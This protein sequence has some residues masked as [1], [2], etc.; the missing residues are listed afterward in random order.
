[1]SI[2]AHASRIERSDLAVGRAHYIQFY[3][4]MWLIANDV[5]IGSAF[6]SFICENSD[7]VG[8]RLGEIIQVLIILIESYLDGADDISCT[9][10]L[11]SDFYSRVAALVE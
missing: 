5:I 3:N 1:M 8:K 6:T 10:G 2:S 11:Y 4:T 7:F 9:V